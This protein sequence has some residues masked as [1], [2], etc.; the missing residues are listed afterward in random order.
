LSLDRSPPLVT[1]STVVPLASRGVG[2]V[3]AARSLPDAVVTLSW[4]LTD[5]GNPW[6]CLVAVAAAYVVGRRSGLS[7]P[8]AAFT[9]ALAL[10]ALGLVLGLKH[11]FA[12]PRPPGAAA[13]GYGFPSGHALGATVFWGGVALLAER[14]SRRLR[15]GVAATVVCLVAAS[16]V[17]VGVHYL[18]DVVVGVAVGVA[19]L[20]VALAAGPGFPDAGA[21]RRAAPTVERGH[22]AAALLLAAGAAAAGLLSVAPSSTELLLALGT[23]LGALLAWRWLAE[24]LP[25]SAAA[26]PG[27]VVAGVV[28]LPVPLATIRGVAE[29]A[30]PSAVTVVVAGAG[31]FLLLALPLVAASLVD[32]L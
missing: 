25:R 1:L 10:G 7:R 28:A 9:L 24:S 31:A 30:L 27:A 14:G 18:V 21:G 2:E 12:L 32:R 26:P 13:D 17:V 4:L 5:L 16:R 11:L 3:A 29:L 15:L 20:A 19:L 8:A 23:S 6:V 22:V